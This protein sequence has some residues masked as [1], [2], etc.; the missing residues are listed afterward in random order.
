V[1][2]LAAVMAE[3]SSSQEAEPYEPEGDD[4]RKFRE[5]LDRKMAESIGC[6]RP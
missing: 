2:T 6:I 1:G 3:S 4:K 5:N